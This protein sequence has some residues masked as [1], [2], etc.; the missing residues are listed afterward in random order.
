MIAF[1]VVER[2]KHSTDDCP[3]SLAEGKVLLHQEDAI[4]FGENNARRTNPK[5]GPFWMIFVA[6]LFDSV[7]LEV[8]DG[9]KYM[10]I[11]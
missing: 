2:R 8:E 10:T 9:P 1:L 6:L 7:D 3:S 11:G 5:K 4:I